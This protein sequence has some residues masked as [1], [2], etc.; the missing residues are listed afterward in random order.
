M[1]RAAARA[2]ADPKAYT[3]PT[4]LALWASDCVYCKKN[5]HTLAGLAKTH[6][7][8]RIVTVAAEQPSAETRP[9]LDH[10][11]VPGERYAYADDVPEALAYAIDP[12]WRGELPRTYLFDGKGGVKAVSGVID[13]AGFRAGLKLK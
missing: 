12:N 11:G 1:C 6:R 8:L 3:Q 5:L 10:T 13:A 7:Q 9:A 4:V 2:V